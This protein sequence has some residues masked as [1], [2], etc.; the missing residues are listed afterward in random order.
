MKAVRMLVV[1]V[2]MSGLAAC[3]TDDGSGGSS[4][5]SAFRN[6]GKRGDSDLGKSAA[7]SVQ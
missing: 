2:L 1:L 4:P 3:D 5:R 7:A 6:L